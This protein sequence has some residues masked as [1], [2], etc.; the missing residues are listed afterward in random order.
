MPK[1]PR[2]REAFERA[3]G[4][5]VTPGVADLHDV[6]SRGSEAEAEIDIL[7]PERGR[8]VESTDLVER[9][10]PEHLAR[11]DREVDPPPC[12]RPLGR[13]RSRRRR[14]GCR[15]A[16]ACAGTSA[17]VRPTLPGTAPRTL[18]RSR[19]IDGSS[20]SG[21]TS[22]ARAPSCRRASL[23]RKHTNGASVD[24]TP[25]L[26]P[27]PT[28]RFSWLR[29][30]RTRSSATSA[31][32]SDPLS[33]TST[34]GST[35]DWVSAERTARSSSPGGSFQVRTT[36]STVIAFITGPR[37]GGVRAAASPPARS[38]ARPARPQEVPRRR[39]PRCRA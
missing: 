8:V 38:R 30:T 35:P 13:A 4:R 31:A 36:T 24:R 27:P 14:C 1:A 29:R 21:A 11:T 15:R 18:A 5:V 22:F 9:L 28:P 10:T 16:R 39:A 2:G 6:P 26:R 25:R 37:C 23:S 17:R 32:V 7:G 3:P 20:T 12:S 34:I 33:T 19:P